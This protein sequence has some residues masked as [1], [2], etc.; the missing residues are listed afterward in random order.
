[1]KNHSRP[2]RRPQPR[3]H[4]DRRPLKSDF[5]NPLRRRRRSRAG[6]SSAST[7]N[8][9]QTQPATARHRPGRTPGLQIFVWIGGLALALAFAGA[10]LVK[11]SIEQGWLDA[12]MRCLLG[13]LLGAALLAGGQLRGRS[14]QIAQSLSAAGVAVLYAVLLGGDRPL[15]PH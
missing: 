3:R 15:S 6:A 10:F 11:Y 5:P 7:S 12:K 9:A 1:M 2:S 14:Q 8:R 13:G 4:R